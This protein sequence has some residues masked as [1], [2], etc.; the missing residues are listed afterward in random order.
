MDCPVVRET[1]GDIRASLNVSRF[2]DANLS[3]VLVA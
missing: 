3:M 2:G 1:G